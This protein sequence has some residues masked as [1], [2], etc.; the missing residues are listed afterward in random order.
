MALKVLIIGKSGSGKTFSLGTLPPAE[1][2]VFAPDKKYPQ[3]PPELGAPRQHY[4]FIPLQPNAIA[5]IKK[6]G[7]NPDWP[8]GKYVDL[9]NTNY[10]AIN[11]IQIISRLLQGINSHRPGIHYVIIDT[12]TH[13]MFDSV[14]RRRDEKGYEKFTDFA[15]EFYDLVDMIPDLRD[16]LFVIFMAHDMPDGKDTDER[17]MQIPAGTLTKE[18]FKPESRFDEVLWA[19]VVGAEDTA[20]YYLSTI[21]NGLNTVRSRIG[22]FPGP[23]IPNDALYVTQCIRAY[24][25]GTEKPEPK[26]INF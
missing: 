2:F 12:V 14:M 6:N 8:I 26:V 1:T 23:R 5:E 17:C 19:N 24:E 25:F 18:K 15:G 4:K 16:D 7:W 10:M 22:V 13:G 11:Q 20:I 9:K 3:L 21:N